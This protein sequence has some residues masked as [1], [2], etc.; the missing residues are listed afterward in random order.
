MQ[1]GY[2]Y[3]HSVVLD[4]ALR[5]LPCTVAKTRE[6]GRNDAG[7]NMCKEH[8]GT[9]HTYEGGRDEINARRQLQMNQSDGAV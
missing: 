1:S 4:R 7:T 8:A 3:S 2:F 9:T 6:E 5:C